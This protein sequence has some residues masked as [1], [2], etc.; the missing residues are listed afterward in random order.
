M[1]DAEIS[2]IYGNTPYAIGAMT[3]HWYLSIGYLSA[4]D[5]SLFTR[6]HCSF[7]LAFFTDQFIMSPKPASTT[8]PPTPVYNS[9]EPLLVL[10]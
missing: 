2:L 1:L 10:P 3:S 9:L 8:L 6:G 4:L 5:V 7:T